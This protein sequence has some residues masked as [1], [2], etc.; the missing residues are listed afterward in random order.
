MTSKLYTYTVCALI[1][2]FPPIFMASSKAST[3]GQ[4]PVVSFSRYSVSVSVFA[5]E[6]KNKKSESFTSYHASI[7]RRY[8]TTDG[9]IKYTQSLNER[10]WLTAAS[11]LERAFWHISELRIDAI[12]ENS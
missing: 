1:I 11:L 4:K 5:T 9:E 2:F 7:S 10:D 3:K 8:V 6:N 12:E